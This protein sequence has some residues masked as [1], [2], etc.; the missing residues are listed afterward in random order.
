MGALIGRSVVIASAALGA[1]CTAAA[2]AVVVGGLFRADA[3][4]R[5][6]LVTPFDVQAVATI[7][8]DRQVLQ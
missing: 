6:G 2:L 7:T 3:A 1:L 8:A 5:N 4:H